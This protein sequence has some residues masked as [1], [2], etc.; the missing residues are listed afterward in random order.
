MIVRRLQDLIGTEA[1]VEGG[2]RDRAAG[3]WRS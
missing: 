3:T 2:D 1:D